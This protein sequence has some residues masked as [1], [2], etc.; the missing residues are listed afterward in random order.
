MELVLNLRKPPFD[1]FT[2][3]F[4]AAVSLEMKVFRFVVSVRL[5]A[6]RFVPAVQQDQLVNSLKKFGLIVINKFQLCQNV[7]DFF[8]H[9]FGA[10]K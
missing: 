6:K 4:A 7:H 3:L 8:V 9:H 1:F 2:A 10:L 5:M